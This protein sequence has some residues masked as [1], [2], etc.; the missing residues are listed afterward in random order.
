MAISAASR[1]ADAAAEP[2]GEGANSHGDENVGL[3]RTLVRDLGRSGRFLLGLLHRLTVLL[4][5][6][7][8]RVRASSDEILA[9]RAKSSTALSRATRCA[10]GS[11]QATR[12]PSGLSSSAG[13]LLLPWF[14]SS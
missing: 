2:R 13:S 12:Q 7:V 1:R 14:L 4:R 5:Y 8:E 3:G 9:A 11:P 10:C 6:L